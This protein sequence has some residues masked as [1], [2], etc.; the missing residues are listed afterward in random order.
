M[1]DFRKWGPCV[2]LALAAA[3][4]V[5]PWISAFKPGWLHHLRH[6]D[7]MDVI[8]WGCLGVA[9]LSN[10]V[11]VL[12]VVIRREAISFAVLAIAVIVLYFNIFYAVREFAYG[13]QSYR[14][15]SDPHLE[16]CAAL[17]NFRCGEVGRV[18]TS[19]FPMHI[20]NHVQEES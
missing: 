13:R 14:E 7:N 18:F 11:G 15:V 2:S 5:Q 17:T 1:N 9:I 3:A 16:T 12:T 6:S 4:L 19:R 8:L 10:L 20:A